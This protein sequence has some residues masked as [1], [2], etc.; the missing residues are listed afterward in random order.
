VAGR[1]G[2]TVDTAWGEQV[3]K[4]LSILLW[5]A[6]A[7]TGASAFAAAALDHGEGVNAVWLVTTALLIYFIAYRYYSRFIA[8]RVLQLDDT[9]QTP[10]LRHND[11]M[12]YVPTNKWVLYGHHF[13]AIAGAGPL[14]GPV[15]AAQMGYLPGAL[16]I[17]VGVVIA[18]AVQDFIVL[19]VSVRRDGKSLGEMIKVELG[20]VPGSLAL[21]GVLAIMIIILAVLSL[22]VV[23]ALTSSP[24]GVFTIAATMPIALLMGVYMRF[25]RPGRVGE[26][27]L[28]GV[29]LLL[30]ALFY[31]QTVAHDPTL[32]PLF[33]LTGPQL[34]W[35]L[36]IY[37][38]V[39]SSLPVWLML[40][41][42]DYLS[43]FLK[44][45]TI[46]ALAI[47][48]YVVAPRL[49]MPPMTRFID[50]SGPV[51]S[52]KLFPFLFI[53][54]ACGAV[55]GFHSLISSGTTP[56]MIEKESHMRLIGFGGMLTESFVA[57]MALTAACVLQPGIYFAMNAPAAVIGTTA[58]NAAEV[59]SNWGFTITPEIITQAA[60]DIGENSILSRAGGAPTLA[61]GMAQI[62]GQ[63]VG[64]K[65]MEALWYHF[66]ILF[67]A[68]FILTA[69][70]AG[71]RVGRFMI[72]DMLGHVYRP[73]GNTQWLPANMIGTGLCVAAWGYFLYQGVVDPLGGI[74]T[75]WQ[76]FG[77]GNQM[78]AGIALILCT[79]VLVKMKRERYAWVTLVP[80]A[81]L[82]VTTMTAGLQKIFSSDPRIGFL[83]LAH[84]FS[85]AAAQGTILAPAKSLAEMQRVAFNN[86]LDAVVCGVFVVLV[87]AMCVFAFKIC[88]SALRQVKPTAIETPLVRVQES[89]I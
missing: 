68:L 17:L 28:F 18:G 85:D 60:K 15:L 4:I 43:T 24:W 47:G 70:D 54:I 87:C 46:V 38:A 49:A 27:S 83:A 23:K 5:G 32:G 89:P 71:T 53:T 1:P 63:A 42:R 48:I 45:G 77:V 76:L 14:V 73:L 56:K 26:A 62:L 16:W 12:D 82:L 19:F 78:L 30:G 13:A 11:G 69:V 9:R 6:L 39:A 7:T 88:L 51:F 37:G 67:E 79:S 66:A 61:V 21:V 72:Q 22:V 2:Q 86:Y 36:I 25:I 3:K 65:S 35:A 57:I 20:P 74:N 40:A 8:N 80:T 84:K 75:L 44:I 41:P 29:V 10:A 34:A 52:G 64:G 33:T 58:A 81:W 31:G 55:S 59:I 50:G